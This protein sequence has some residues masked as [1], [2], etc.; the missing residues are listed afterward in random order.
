MN[1]LEAYKEVRSRVARDEKVTLIAYTPIDPHEADYECMRTV[2]TFLFDAVST[3]RKH[4]IARVARQC[5]TPVTWK[6]YLRYIHQ[7]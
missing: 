4:A 5:P 6:I 7:S 1:T 2:D 3:V